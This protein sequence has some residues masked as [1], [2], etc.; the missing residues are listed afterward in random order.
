MEPEIVAQFH[1]AT[2]QPRQDDIRAQGKEIHKL[3]RDTMDNIKPD[4]KGY[5]WL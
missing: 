1:A 5:V 2:V 3:L 4:K